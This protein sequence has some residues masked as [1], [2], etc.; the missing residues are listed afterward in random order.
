M[1]LIDGKKI[2]TTIKTEIAAEVKRMTDKGARP[3]HLAAILV[4]EDPASE[5]YVRNKSKSCKEVGF[6]SSTYRF[7]ADVSE[8]E[9]LDT[10]G[11]IN[12]DPDI[13]GLIVQ[14]PLPAHIDNQ[15][16]IEAISPEKDVDGFHPINVGRT[17]IGLPSYVSAT[18]YGILELLMRAGIETSGKNCVV[19]G[20]S[21]IVGKPMSILMMRNEEPGNATVTVCHSKTKNLREITSA[22]DILIVAIGRPGFVT[23]DMVKE[24]AVVIDVGIHRV[25]SSE[26]KSGFRLVGDVLFDEVSEKVAHITPVPGGVGPMTI[27]SLLMNT[28]KACKKEIYG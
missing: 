5:T 26:T 1:E 9:I 28:M 3:P 16:V 10:V 12:R 2:A 13:D 14:L 19:L 23:A 11:F 15:K 7:P 6:D 24:G 22:A 4:G 27:V 25:E 8:Q 20:R 21:N 18:P 17:T